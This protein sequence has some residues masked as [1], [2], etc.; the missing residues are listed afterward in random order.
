VI[1]ETDTGIESNGNFS[2]QQGAPFAL[3]SLQGNY[4]IETSGVSAAALQ[5]TTGQFGSNGAGTIVSGVIDTNTGGTTLALG[6]AATG[7]YSTPAA[8]GR[9]TITLTAGALNYV[10]YIVSPSQIYIL[11]IQPGELAAGAMLK[12]F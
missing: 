9:V 8:T 7:T 6:Q 10:G 3:A 12:Q 4:A 2:F 5:V 1:Q 11:G